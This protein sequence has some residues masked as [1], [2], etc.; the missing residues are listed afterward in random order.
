[1]G[2]RVTDSNSK[3]LATHST[4]SGKKKTYFSSEMCCFGD[5]LSF[6]LDWY[7]GNGK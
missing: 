7:L 4:V 5:C 2:L 1:M 3:V 6:N